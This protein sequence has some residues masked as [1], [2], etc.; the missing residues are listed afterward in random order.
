[1]F[2]YKSCLQISQL[3][4]SFPI[5]DRFQFLCVDYIC[6]YDDVTQVV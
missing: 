1:M 3:H 6:N 5:L 4:E 2:V